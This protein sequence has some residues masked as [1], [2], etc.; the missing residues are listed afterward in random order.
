[1]ISQLVQE[2]TDWLVIFATDL[3]IPLMAFAFLCG[4]GLRSLIYY[5]IK[6]EEWFAKEFDR[7]VDT[8]LDVR[9][10]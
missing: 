5:T 10:I 1:M 4:I 8:F 2:F 7:R 6:R 9:R 3:L